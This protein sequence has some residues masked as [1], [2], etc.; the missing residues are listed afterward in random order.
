MSRRTKTF[1]N[2]FLLSFVALLL[3][4]PSF[5]I[6]AMMSGAQNETT[7]SLVSTNLAAV[8]ASASPEEMLPI[9]VQFESDYSS[10]LIEEIVSK[11]SIVGIEVRT[12]FQY[13]PFISL[14][15]DSTA[16]DKLTTL[17]G[18]ISINFDRHISAEP[19]DTLVA[20][21]Q[22]AVDASYIHPSEI[23]QVDG[24]WN[25]GYNG[26]GIT[27]AVI[28]SGADGNHPDLAG[29]LVGFYDLV[30]EV[31]D[32]D[33][34]DGIAA[35][36]D[37]GHGTACTWLVTGSGEG[38]NYS[39]TGLAVGAGV[40]VI[41]SLDSS[42][43]ADDSV[44]AEGIEYAITA[45]VDII[46]LSVGGAWL[47]NPL[48]SDAS[49][50]AAKAAV[51]AGI[52]VVVAAGN[53]GPATN[54]ITSPG[55][56]EEVITV[57]SSIGGT[58]AVSFSSRGPV[59]RERTEPVGAVAKPDVLA[60]GYNVLS[61]II[62][63]ANP[64]EYPPY[65]VSQFD[66]DYTL[67][68]GTSASAP[69]IAA[70][71]AVLID[72]HPALTPIQVK[73]FLMSG[74]TDLGIDP[75]E[76]GYG[77]VNATR[78]SELIASSSGVATLIAPLRYPTLPGTSQV[79]IVGDRRDPTNATVIS[80]VN[81]GNL[82]I[83]MTGNASQF[84]VTESEVYV[85]VGYSYFSISLDVPSNLPLSALGTYSGSLNL[86]SGDDIIATMELNLLITTYGGRL[87]VDMGHHSTEDPDDVSY[88]R[89][90]TE[91]LREQGMVISE[92]PENWEDEFILPKA[93]DAASLEATEVLL[94]MDTEA[95]YTQNEIDLIHSFVNGGGTL[96][97]LS[98]GFDSQTNQPAFSIASYNQIL[99]PY[100]IQC[101]E[102][103]IGEN[104]GDVYGADHGGAVDADT[105]TDGVRN[106]YVLN[107]G[108]LSIDSSIVGAKGLVWTDAARTH[109]IVAV[110]ESGE[111]KVIALSDGSILYDTSI[112]DAI[113]SGADNLKLL[114]NIAEAIIP[115]LPRIYDV[116]MYSANVGEEANLTA[117]IFDEDMESVEITITNPNG[118]EIDA[119]VIESLGYK[120]TVE[121]ILEET[122]FYEIEIIATNEQ[123]YVR[124]YSK[125]ILIPVSALEDEV[126]MGVVYG[127]L[128]I[129]GLALAYVGFLKFYSGKKR[130]A[131][132]EREWSPEWES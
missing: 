99:Q 96:I 72:K 111:G 86:I 6:A 109:A 124:T 97:I 84:V 33:P 106:V 18:V 19:L 118:N 35:Y 89:Y 14:Y 107:G 25:E 108:S 127:L 78:S 71:A 30:G 4:L 91:Y 88:Y 119:P 49:A 98:E 94:I 92:Y 112:Y 82:D 11:S 100:G 114:E 47:D 12:V 122:G 17:N 66:A 61:G 70:V 75:L 131:P 54:T 132:F 39:Y 27:V 120:Y 102:Y 10:Y 116:K 24:L 101:E 42:G 16:I 126:L 83:E 38:T 2:Y 130:N 50:N 121:F 60:P 36:D 73:A 5:G 79:L 48:Y 87:L 65:N 128:G 1:S 53:S 105:L 13:I 21:F 26:S 117:Y 125:T 9:T 68:S 57:G 67:W 40:L 52:I 51:E 69:Q 76:Q 15:A 90:F 80:T 93:F 62:D 123:G 55:I 77:L 32:L 7:Q 56:V 110:A 64:Y 63:N 29:K 74:A 113:L 58:D 43:A 41:K 95:A 44:I 20:P 34:S 31:N 129:V 28:D 103:W 46:S 59:Y 22:S 3:I 23:L 104:N 37:N 81:R 85:S 115:N 45:N 8:M